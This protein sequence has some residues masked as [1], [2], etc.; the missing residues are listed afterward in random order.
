MNDSKKLKSFVESI[1][2]FGYR[3][4]KG[5]DYKKAS[6]SEAER[7]VLLNK[8]AELNEEV[9]GLKSEVETLEKREIKLPFDI[10]IGDPTP[11]K[12]SQR[13]TYV[14]EVAGFHKT[15]LKDKLMF[16]IHTIHLLQEDEKVSEKQNDLLKGAI[17]AFRELDRW[18][19]MMISETMANQGSGEDSE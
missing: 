11:Q 6:N 10:R 14:A 7:L 9:V 15:T 13:K 16:M 1:N 4:V 17:Y 18:G 2:V 8:N 19:D 3:F 12:A 5:E